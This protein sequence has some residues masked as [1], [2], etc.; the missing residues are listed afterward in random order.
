MMLRGLWQCLC[1]SYESEKWW[2]W[3]GSP[4]RNATAEFGSNGL[5]WSDSLSPKINNLPLHRT[6]SSLS[7]EYKSHLLKSLNEWGYLL[8]LVFKS[9]VPPVFSFAHQ[10]DCSLR[11]LP[12]SQRLET[13]NMESCPSVGVRSVFISISPSAKSLSRRESKN[14]AFLHAI[15]RTPGLISYAAKSIC[16]LI[17]LL[18]QTP[19]LTLENPSL[20]CSSWRPWANVQLAPLVQVPCSKNLQRRVLGLSCT[21]PQ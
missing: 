17:H 6:K 2:V 16:L 1:R 11:S 20:A 9:L 12:A 15:V 19:P 18:K 8:V 7:V 21:A 4:P 10:A 3:W 14:K 13:T 5:T